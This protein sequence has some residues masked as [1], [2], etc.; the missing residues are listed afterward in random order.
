LNE[1]HAL[2][3]AEQRAADRAILRQVQHIAIPRR[4]SQQMEE[5][6]FMQ[7][8][9][10]HRQRR[11]VL[12]LLAHPRFRA[13]FDFLELRA[14]VVA[15]LGD[16]LAFWRGMQG[17]QREQFLEHQPLCTE[18]VASKPRRRRRKRAASSSD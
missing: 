5:I 10:Q 17:E 4:F 13:A 11:R 18:D 8:R 9:L 6:W 15:Q 12:K 1:G 16:E 14:S 3:V 7:T 2:A